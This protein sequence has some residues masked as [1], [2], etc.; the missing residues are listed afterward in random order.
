MSFSFECLQDNQLEKIEKINNQLNLFPM[1]DFSS[2]LYIKKEVIKDGEGNIIGSYFVHLTS[3]IGLMLDE[4]VNNLTKA[5]IISQLKN[6]IEEDCFKFGIE[7]THV[8]VVPTNDKEYAN[9]LCKHM[10]FK[11]AT[12]IPLYRQLRTK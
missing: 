10:E 12:G 5:K 1:P 6:K 8:F 7:D 4:K 11:P 2:P 9:F 3:E